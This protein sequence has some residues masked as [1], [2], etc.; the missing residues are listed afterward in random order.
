M[1]LH[2]GWEFRIVDGIGHLLP[3]EAPQTYV[4]LVADWMGG[5]A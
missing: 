5:S 2:P 1:E 4:G 3:V